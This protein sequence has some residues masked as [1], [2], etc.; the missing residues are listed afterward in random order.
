M[1]PSPVRSASA[2]AV[3]NSIA[4]VAPSAGNGAAST[5]GEAT[6]AP[7]AEARQPLLLSTQQWTLI[8]RKQ[9]QLFHQKNFCPYGADCT[10]SHV[11]T[12]RLPIPTGDPPPEHKLY[13]TYKQYRH[14]PL[15]S[16]DF[17]EMT[18][19]DETG[20]SWHTA[21]LVCP[22]DKTVYHAAGGTTSARTSQEGVYWYPTLKDARE[23][24]AGIVLEAFRDRGIVPRSRCSSPSTAAANSD[25]LPVLRHRDWMVPLNTRHCRDFNLGKGCQYGAQCKFAHV[26][27]PDICHN[28]SVP[29]AVP[30]SSA[31]NAPAVVPDNDQNNSGGGQDDGSVPHP[32]ALPYA[33]MTNFRV[34]LKP[35]DY[36]GTSMLD[37]NGVRWCTSALTC[38][39]E[40]TVYYASGGR[41]GRVNSQGIYWY[42]SEEDAKAAVA[43]V[44][45]ESFKTRGL[46]C[47]WRNPFERE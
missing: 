41:R 34:E 45:L 10:S 28:P 25:P 13:E 1:V 21:A 7:T 42:P 17:K 44:V 27:Y 5:A 14:V 18:E 24:V 37:A 36:C 16:S 35:H 11:Y 31:V 8:K 47:S 6:A 12:P 22:V 39:S 20:L 38:P 19:K 33:Y 43:A 2:A 30:T 29:S 23:A 46:Y 15:A 4:A 3:P 9:C 26:H 40:K 32:D